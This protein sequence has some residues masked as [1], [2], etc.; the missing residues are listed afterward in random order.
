MQA[1]I[2]VLAIVAGILLGFWI[3]TVSTKREL[4][5]LDQRNR[6]SLD[7]LGALQKQLTQAHAESAARAGFESLARE[8]AATVTQV[9]AEVAG[10]RSELESKSTHASSLSARISQLEADLN[11]ERQ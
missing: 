6:E 8:R 7:A 3:R 10:L 2:A 1:L 5:L 11:N 9:N 4:G